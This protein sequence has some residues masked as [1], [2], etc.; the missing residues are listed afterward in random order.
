LTR[1]DRILQ[2]ASACGGALRRAISEANPSRDRESR[3]STNLTE[4]VGTASEE[5]DREDFPRTKSEFHGRREMHGKQP[6]KQLARHA[7]AA[8]SRQRTESPENLAE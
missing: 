4:S 1:T 8:I 5:A 2:T 7:A 3:L 6:R